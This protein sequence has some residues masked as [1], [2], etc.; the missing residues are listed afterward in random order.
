M[1]QVLRDRVI[2]DM[3]A[4]LAQWDCDNVAAE[5]IEINEY[6][7]GEKGLVATP[8]A[9]Q[10]ASELGRSPADIVGEL[11]EAFRDRG[12][13]ESVDTIETVGGYV[14]FHVAE[15]EFTTQTLE[16]IHNTEAEYGVVD[17]SDTSAIFELSSPNIAKPLHIGHLRNTV[18]GDVLGNVLEARGYDLVRDNH[19]GDWGVQFGH[20]LY[21]YEQAEDVD[22]FEDTPIDYLLDLYQRYGQQKPSFKMRAAR[23]T[24]SGCGI[25][26][27][28]ISPIWKQAMRSW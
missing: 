21:E 7:D 24:W 28:S 23:T 25:Q 5:P 9:Y 1:L 3:R 20:L 11:A 10:L 4:I 8:V 18:L 12:P 16:Q 17:A 13:I 2:E 14:N 26:A 19:I 15:D 22:R 27:G 6:A